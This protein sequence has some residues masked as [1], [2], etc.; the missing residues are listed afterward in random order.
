[1]L[2][3]PIFTRY[4]KLVRSYIFILQGMQ[5]NMVR[6]YYVARFLLSVIKELQ[7]WKFFSLKSER[8]YIVPIVHKADC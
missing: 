7:V 4:L 3:T 8:Q 1:M 5:E 2:K 6:N